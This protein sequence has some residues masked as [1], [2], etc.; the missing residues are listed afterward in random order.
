M[1]SERTG[2][3]CMNGI[4]DEDSA[5]LKWS[6]YKALPRANGVCISG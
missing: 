1:F 5:V 3:A 6:E 4:E 2:A